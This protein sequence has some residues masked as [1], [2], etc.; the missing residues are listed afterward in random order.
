MRIFTTLGAETL[1]MSLMFEEAL[2]TIGF[3]LQ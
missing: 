3:V 2:A 1:A